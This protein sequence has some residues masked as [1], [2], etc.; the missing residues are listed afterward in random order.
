MIK[1]SIMVKKSLLSLAIGGFGIGMTEFVIM[2]LLP[3]VAQNL[4]IT[5]PEAGYLISS[6]ALGV[7][8]GAPILAGSTSKYSPKTVL[9]ALMLMFTVF[10]GISALAPNF[11]LLMVARFLSGLPH[12]AFFGVGAVVASRLADKGKMAQAVA[13]MITGLTL[14]NVFGVPVGTYLGHTYSW[15]LSFALISL[16][17]LVTVFCI[18][19]WIPEIP[20]NAEASLRNDLKIFKNPNLWLSICITSIGFGGFFAWM[21]YIAPLLTKEAGFASSSI[22]LMMTVAGLGM[23]CGNILGGKLADRF[24]P[25]KSIIIIMLIMTGLLILNGFMTSSPALIVVLTFLTGVCALAMGAPLQMLLIF[26]SKGAEILGSAL[27]QTSFNI[28]NALGA[29]LGGIP[30]AL[31]YSYSSPQFVGSMMS[32]AGAAIALI[33]FLRTKHES[34]DGVEVPVGH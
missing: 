20:G 22:P 7:V 8:V 2:G 34:F 5:I 25:V 9:M 17:G 1:V 29:Y 32:F 3:N 31:G 24:S 4:S 23:T 16:I 13:T 21:S 6:Y 33:L 27:G 11:Y 18:K 12:G 10:N 30:L 15:R 19:L 14:A 28:G 26:N